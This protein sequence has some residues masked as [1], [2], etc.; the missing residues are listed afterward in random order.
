MLTCSILVKVI[1]EGASLEEVVVIQT[2]GTSEDNHVACS[3]GRVA[4]SRGGFTSLSWGSVLLVVVGLVLQGIDVLVVVVVSLAFALLV[5]LLC[6]VATFAEAT[7]SKGLS[8]GLSGIG[9]GGIG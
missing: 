5:V 3:D 9:L 4:F 7:L 6:V 8:G 1:V 2:K